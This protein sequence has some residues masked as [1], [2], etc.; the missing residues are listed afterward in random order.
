MHITIMIHAIYNCIPYLVHK[1]FFLKDF[2]FK[3]MLKLKPQGLVPIYIGAFICAMFN[4]YFTR[5]LHVK[6][7]SFHLI[8]LFK[9]SLETSKISSALLI[10]ENTGF[11]S[12]HQV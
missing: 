7:S 8:P 12:L 11:F 5:K 6:Y 3:S 10:L 9:N 4:L 2:L 1:N